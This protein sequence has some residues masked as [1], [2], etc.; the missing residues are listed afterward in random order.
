MHSTVA[1]A[2]LL[3]WPWPCVSSGFVGFGLVFSWGKGVNGVT[4]SVLESIYPR[5]YGFIT[6]HSSCFDPIFSLSRSRPMVR[7]ATRMLP[8]LTL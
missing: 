7:Y 2:A 1:P 6:V 4:V 3:T 8:C 5:F